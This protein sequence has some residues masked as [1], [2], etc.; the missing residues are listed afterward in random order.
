MVPLLFA[1]TTEELF[2]APYK[3][4]TATRQMAVIEYNKVRE[5]SLTLDQYIN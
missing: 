2:L 4:A 5:D 1:S 3:K